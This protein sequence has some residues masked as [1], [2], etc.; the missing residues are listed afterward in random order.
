MVDFRGG[1]AVMTPFFC[2]NILVSDKLGYT[3]NFTF[4]DHLELRK[5]SMWSGPYGIKQNIVPLVA[6]SCK[7]RLEKFQIGL[8]IK[9]GPSEAITKFKVK[10]SFVSFVLKKSL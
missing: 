3:P 4:P 2:R 9:I 1:G 8:K 5:Q 6:L 10:L 7:L